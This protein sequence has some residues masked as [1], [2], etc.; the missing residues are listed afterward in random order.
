MRNL[1]LD[2]G[3]F[4]TEV[5]DF[6]PNMVQCR[7]RIC[8]QAQIKKRAADSITLPAALQGT[9][10]LQERHEK[11]CL[12]HRKAPQLF[13]LNDSYEYCRI[14][15]YT[16]GPNATI[17]AQIQYAVNI[18]PSSFLPRSGRFRLFLIAVYQGLYNRT[19][20]A[21]N[22]FFKKIRSSQRSCK[23]WFVIVTSETGKQPENRKKPINT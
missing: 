23:G 12:P 14:M 9:E 2:K 10:V 4:I 8:H 1:P 20:T 6:L 18:F 22:R 21:R 5:G 17:P 13:Y 15:P 19:T 16:S 11:R 3:H 7:S